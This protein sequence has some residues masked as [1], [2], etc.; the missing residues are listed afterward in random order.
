MAERSLID[1]GTR[2]GARAL[3]RLEHELVIWLTTVSP[4]GQP[5]SAP[6]WFLW[7]DGTLLVYSLKGS[8][9]ARNIGTHPLVSLNLNATPRGGDIVALE[10]E[11]RLDPAAPRSDQQPTYAA[12]YRALIDD[13][14]WTP[15]SFAADYPD[16]IRIRVTKVRLG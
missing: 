15:A 8:V 12:K 6:V 11:A 14:G 5:Q 9:R 10:G 1:P 16:P 2:A 7:E 4:T 13:Y 3:E